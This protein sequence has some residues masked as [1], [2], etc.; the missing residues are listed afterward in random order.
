MDDVVAPRMK[1]CDKFSKSLCSWTFD[2]LWFVIND[3]CTTCY[4]TSWP[5]PCDPTQNPKHLGMQM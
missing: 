5:K 2:Y 3:L 4:S 1:K